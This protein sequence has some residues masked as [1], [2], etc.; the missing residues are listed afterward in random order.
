[1]AQE[2]APEIT[3]GYLFGRLPADWRARA[4]R[5]GCSTIH[6]DQRHLRRET[7]RA[8]IDAGYP[9]LAYTVND[10]ARACEVIG[11]GLAA[12]FTDCPD[13]ILVALENATKRSPS[14]VGIHT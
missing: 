11:W 4:E 6:C 2:V 10:P 7:A 8:V 3:R 5:L 1:M 9:L 13:R 12:V 14:D